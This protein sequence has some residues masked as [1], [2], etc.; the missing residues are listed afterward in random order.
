[1]I[2]ASPECRWLG[3]V[4]DK[5]RHLWEATY[6][7][8]ATDKSIATIGHVIECIEPSTMRGYRYRHPGY[9]TPSEY[10]HLLVNRG[11]H[12]YLVSDDDYIPFI[13]GNDYTR[14]H[15]TI[16]GTRP[17][18][19]KWRL[20]GKG[21]IYGR[22]RKA[23]NAAGNDA[24]DEKRLVFRPEE[25]PITVTEYVHRFCP[26]GG[27]VVDDMMGCGVTAMACIRLGMFFIGMDRD[28]VCTTCVF[29][30]VCV[31]VCV[32]VCRYLLSHVMVC[33]TYVP[34][35][36]CLAGPGDGLGREEEIA[37][38]LCFLRVEEPADYPWD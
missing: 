15:S 22:W 34:T 10:F 3:R 9:V 36:V 14:A 16:T 8:W 1:M 29:L 7:E 23:K 31:C 19:A 6:L 28:P 33:F 26:P 35:S 17:L 13:V 4:S 32:C 11:G 12:P 38:V 20:T 30:C 21:A 24:K 25:N 5:T 18:N 37:F 2:L 27:V